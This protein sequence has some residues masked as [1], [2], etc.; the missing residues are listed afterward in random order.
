M[1]RQNLLEYHAAL[2]NATVILVTFYV[3]TKGPVPAVQL[4][5]AR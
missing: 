5:C 4:I 1:E 3:P 2:L